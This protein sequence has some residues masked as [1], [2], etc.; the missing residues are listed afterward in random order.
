M[1]RTDFFLHGTYLLKTLTIFIDVF[2]LFYFIQCLSTFSSI[3][4]PCCLCAWLL[5]LFHLTEMR[6]SQSAYLLIYLSL[7]TLMSIRRTG[8][9]LV[10]SEDFYWCFQ[11][12]LLHS[13]SFAFF[14]YKSPLLSVCI[15]FSAISSNVDEVLSINLSANLFVFED[16]NAYCKDRLTYSGGTDTPDELL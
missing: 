10:D 13:V 12:V 5:V 9:I 4:N 11:L 6:F 2:N 1:W 7:E 15:V 8:S 3:N 14:R 16:F